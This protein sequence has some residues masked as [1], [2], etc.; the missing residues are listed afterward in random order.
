[1]PT[2]DLELQLQRQGYRRVAG[3]D[4]AGRGP[5]AGPVV[6][7]A[8]VLPPVSFDAQVD[9][10]PPWL[11]LVDDSKA[12]SPLQ[13]QRA[14]DVIE[15]HACAIGVGMASHEEID[16]I[17]IGEATRCAMRRAVGCLPLRASHLLI[18]YV[19]LDGC[20]VPFQSV[21]HGDRI[22][23]SI[24]AASIVAKVTRDWLMQQADVL[25]PG[26]GFSKHKGYGTARHLRL[27]AERG[28]CPIHRRSF[29][30]LRSAVGAGSGPG[31]E[32]AAAR[33]EA[34]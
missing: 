13:R 34:G 15:S 29:N 25:Y 19:R 27:L 24:A 21:V 2:F 12:L 33:G 20:G 4:E 3:V 17:G 28:P 6:A 7:A 16:G 22:S 31:S 14:M 32:N 30:P 1:M 26:Y 10:L 5:L 11:D 18:D 8:V 23:Y 9:S